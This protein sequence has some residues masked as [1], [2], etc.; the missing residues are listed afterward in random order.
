MEIRERAQAIEKILRPVVDDAGYELVDLQLRSEFGRWVLRLLVDRPG[1]I[2]LDECARLSREVSPHLE[3]AD[4]LPFRYA[5]EVSSPGIHR[6][7][8]TRADFERF[9]G[10]LVAVQLEEPLEGRKN[11][12]GKN[13]G[14]DGEG[15]LIL[16]EPS[17]AKQ[18]VIGIDRIR[19]AHLD[20]ELKF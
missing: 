8:K 16:E 9:A 19:K 17:T 6:P 4:L 5:L 13:L 12:R 20:P 3:V 10:E 14:L 11:F 15:R 2:T 7:L 18:I 1:G